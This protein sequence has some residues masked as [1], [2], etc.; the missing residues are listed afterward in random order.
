MSYRP[1]YE[2]PNYYDDSD[3]EESDWQE[4][5]DLEEDQY[6]PYNTVNS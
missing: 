6:G 4:M 1:T 5:E 3:Y 2:D